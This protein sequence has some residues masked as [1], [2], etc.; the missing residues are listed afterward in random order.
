MLITGAQV[1]AASSSSTPEHLWRFPWSSNAYIVVGLLWCVSHV[2]CLSGLVG[3]RRSGHGG[4][5]RAALV[6]AGLAVT[7]TALV[8]AGEI[9][10]LWI[11]DLSEDSHAATIVG[12]VY[13][14]A[15][16]VAIVG[17]ALLGR[18]VLR[19]HS[20]EG[21]RR[22]VPLTM[23]GWG[24]MLLW[25]PLTPLAPVGSFVIDALFVALGTALLTQP[26]AQ[27]DVE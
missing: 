27:P 7:G 16:L 3:L 19:H 8:L 6:G 18:Q 9:A 17:L 23:A 26:L 21:W 11:G 10:G 2:L 4:P 5:G 13:A 20:W 14:V 12:S 25:L 22:W 24:I 15:T 1:A